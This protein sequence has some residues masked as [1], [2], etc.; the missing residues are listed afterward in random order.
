M[1]RR[2]KRGRNISGVLLLDKPE[3]MTS[4]KALQE[5]KFL[6]KAAKAGHTGSLDPLATGL[7]PIC[8]GE[9]T[10]L[11][12][13]LLDADK[14]YQVRVKLGETTTTADAEG[15][16]IERADPSGVT[17]AALA[18]VLGEFLGE[19]QQLPPMYSAIKHQGERLYKLARQGVEVERETR[20][21]H[22]HSL[23]LLSFTLPEFEMDVHCSKGTYVRTLAEDIGKR[24]GCGAYVSGL[25]RSGV[26]PY[27]DR[28]MVTLE[29]VQQAFAEKRFAE[30][31]EW[32]LPLESALAEW[33]EVALSADAAFYM[34]QGQPILVPNAPTSGWVRLYANKTDFLGVGQILDDGRVAPK[35]LMQVTN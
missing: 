35:R 20:P 24:L 12:A 26:G 15:E 18:E 21:I 30:M 8:F 33:P 7:L 11:S 6:Y 34:K 10:K 19:Q 2:R 32:L 22:I 3:G 9:A 17:E 13:F 23:D 14:H 1:G 25:R 16:V 27:D 5:V 4:N 28:S 29:R 31:D